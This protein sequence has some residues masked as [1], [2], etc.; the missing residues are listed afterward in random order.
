MR[1][2]LYLK[3]FFASGI[4]F[5]LVFGLI[6]A[7]LAAAVGALPGAP[8]S[9]LQGAVVG[10]LLGGAVTGIPF[11][12]IMALCLGTFHFSRSDDPRVRHQRAV[13]LEVNWD[14]AMRLCQEGTPEMKP[15]FFP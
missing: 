1:W 11:G 10:F 6:C 13:V 12:A 8:F 5:G 3:I 15:I 2:G 7:P 4:P 14:Q 9:M